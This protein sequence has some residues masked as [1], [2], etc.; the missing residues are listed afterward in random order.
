M[1][2]WIVEV[3]GG[4]VAERACLDPGSSIRADGVECRTKVD[5]CFPDSFE[6]SIEFSLLD[7][8]SVVLESRCSPSRDLHLK[9]FAYS[10]DR[11]GAINS[12]HFETH[13]FGV[14]LDASIKVV[15]F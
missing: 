13:D 9:I 5:N 15:H 11:E 4:G 10:N 12:F 14:E 8:E 1:L 2:V 7:R 6:D 3:K